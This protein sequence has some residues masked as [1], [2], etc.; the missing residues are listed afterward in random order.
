MVQR[1]TKKI[2]WLLAACIVIVGS[3]FALIE[4]KNTHETIAVTQNAGGLAVAETGILP[5]PQN[6]DWRAA[7]R[8]IVPDATNT[9]TTT[10]LA[11]IPKAV[12]IYGGANATEQF[13]RELFAK[14]LSLTNTANPGDYSN[15]Q[16]VVDKYINQAAQS[17]KV[18]AY[19]AKDFRVVADSDAAIHEY[20]N[21]V[22]AMLQAA[23][24]ANTVDNEITVFQNAVDNNDKAELAKLDDDLAV[25]QNITHALLVM[26]VPE[27]FVSLHL[28]MLNDISTITASINSMKLVFDDPITAMGGIQSYPSAAG[29]FI[30]ILQSVK[31]LLASMGASYTQGE[32]GY[33]FI[34]SL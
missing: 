16:A 33:S 19:T 3:L 12:G 32:S 34:N 25:Y 20:G 26:A 15:Y 14:Y 5:L 10:D 31:S 29:N 28:A 27:S 22:G 21:E 30:P 11:S 17:Q 4:Y 9:A 23:L 13:S 1:P 8:D 7:L 2:I 24:A 18:T 6:D